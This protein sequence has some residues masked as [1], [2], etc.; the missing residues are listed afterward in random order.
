MYASRYVAAHFAQWVRIRLKIAASFAAFSGETEAARIACRLCLEFLAEAKIV[1]GRPKTRESAPFSHHL[2]R[3]GEPTY[4]LV[5]RSLFNHPNV[6][7]RITKGP[8]QD[9]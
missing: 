1:P 8:G 7:T 5:A 4:R 9:W 6:R 2:Q 3:P